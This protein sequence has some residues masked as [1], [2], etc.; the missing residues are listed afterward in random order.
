VNDNDSSAGQR[1][2]GNVFAGL[3]TGPI[4]WLG[5]IDYIVDDGFPTGRRRL[6]AGLLEANWEWRQGHNVKLTGEHFDPDTDVAND[7]RGRYSLVYEYTPFQFVQVRGGVRYYDGIPQ[8][9]DQNERE[10]F[11]ELHGFF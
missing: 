9:P 1:R 2:M 3:R 11:V 6:W 10:G 7:Q 8:A 5:E 4:G